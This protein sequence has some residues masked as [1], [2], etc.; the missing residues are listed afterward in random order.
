MFLYQ[1]FSYWYGAGYTSVEFWKGTHTPS[2]SYLTH[3]GL[4]LF[5]IV[6][7]LFHETIDW[8][9]S[10]PLRQ[11]AYLRPYK[12]L[13]I[14]LAVLLALATLGMVFLGAYIAWFVLPLAAWAAVLILRP[15]QSDIKRLFLFF[16]GTGLVLTLFVEV[17]VLKGDIG[18]MNTVFKFYLQVWTL[19]ALTAGAAAY[20]LV[21]DLINWGHNSAVLFKTAACILLFGA[22]LFPLTAASDK[23]R[24]RYVPTASHSL[25][26]S[27]YMLGASYTENNIN[28]ST[29]YDMQLEQDYQGIRWLQDNVKGSPVIVEGSVTEYRWGARYTI[30]TGLPAVI[31]WNWHQRQQRGVTNPEWVTNRIDEVNSFYSTVDMDETL[32]F[33]KKYDVKY[34][35]VGQMEQAIYPQVGISK[36]QAYN[37]VYWK[38]VFSYKQTTIYEIIPGTY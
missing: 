22:A 33:L 15:D 34:I 25:D 12:N 27:N 30:N 28:N 6:T 24:D 32:K 35:I 8:M 36:F 3:W 13:L 5:F 16:I 1:P 7:W 9:A 29:D 10:T 18:R 38:P 21:T 26:G 37:N 20:W 2:W 23:I 14:V 11:L 17:I 31:G 19:F 4:F